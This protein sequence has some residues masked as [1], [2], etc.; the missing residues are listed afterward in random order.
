MI[1][2]D[3][4]IDYSNPI[5]VCILDKNLTVHITTIYTLSVQFNLKKTSTEN[6]FKK[7]K[8]MVQRCFNTSAYSE[9]KPTLGQWV[10]ISGIV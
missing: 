2:I 1:S 8:K 3:K 5:F 4:K 6:N 7:H 9:Y 10:T